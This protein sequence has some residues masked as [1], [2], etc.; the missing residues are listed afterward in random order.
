MVAQQAAEQQTVVVLSA[1]LQILRYNTV[2]V[3]LRRLRQV[4][5]ALAV[6]LLALGVVHPLVAHALLYGRGSYGTCTYQDCQQTTGQKTVTLPSGL[7]VSI[8]L[9]NGQTIPADGYTIVVTPLN[10]Q[11]K[12]FKQVDFYINGKLVHSGQ[13]DNTGTVEWFWDPQLLPG[14]DITIVITDTDGN[15]VTQKFHVVVGGPAHAA[16]KSNGSSGVLQQL[17]NSTERIFRALPKPVVYGFPFFLFVLLGVNVLLLL[18]QTQRELKSYRTLQVVLKRARAVAEAKKTLTELVSHYLRTPLTVLLG[19]IDLLQVD[20]FVTSP[21]VDLKSV[22]QRM[23]TKIEGLIAETQS[24]GDSAGAAQATSPNAAAFWRQPG[25]FLPILLIAVIVLPFNFLAAHAGSFSITQINLAAQIIIFAILALTTY[26]VFRRLQLHKRD[27][28]ELK[29]VL[30]AETATNQARDLLIANTVTTLNDDLATLDSLLARLGSSQASEFMQNGQERFHDVLTKFAIAGKLQGSSSTEPFV[31]LRVGELTDR[32]TANLQAKLA[33]HHITIRHA[34]D[35]NA[36]VQ[37]Q[38]AE[39]LSF[40]LSSVIDN[41]I[42]Y[43]PDN[44]NIEIS[45]AA[46]AASTTLTVT[47]HGQG[48]PPEKLSLLF[49]PFSK[50]EGAEVFTHEG[51]GFSLYLDKLILTYLHG[52]IAISSKL[53]QGTTVVIHLPNQSPEQA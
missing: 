24:L 34:N 30:A 14:N 5:C 21:A 29:Q 18:L 26:Q 43:S 2:M 25:L 1:S 31:P 28:H 37:T 44:S 9:S 17:Y 10:G 41:A 6:V 47:D 8:N 7:Q 36:F 23:R 13:P 42:A 35:P 3:R 12:S 48:M 52:D 16:S 4:A 46:S 27:A 19:G 39:L 15:Q 33:E 50:I 45:A 38:S 40:V 22:A 11:G 53:G 51:M 49:Q 20:E 32:A